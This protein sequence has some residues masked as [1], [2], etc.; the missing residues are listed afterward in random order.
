MDPQSTTIKIITETESK[1]DVSTADD[2]LSVIV[3]L[4][5]FEISMSW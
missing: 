3:T 1:H 5:N 4:L 2:K